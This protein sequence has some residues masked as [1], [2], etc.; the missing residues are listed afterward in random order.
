MTTFSPFWG[1][2]IIGSILLFLATFQVLLE[3]EVS[4]SGFVTRQEFWLFWVASMI[5]VVNLM[6]LLIGGVLL[7]GAIRPGFWSEIVYPKSKR[8]E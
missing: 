7:L 5:P 8:K 6:I 4:N 3:L 1:C 2:A